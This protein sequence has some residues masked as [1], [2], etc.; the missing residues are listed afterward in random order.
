MSFYVLVK[1][2]LYIYYFLYLK[3]SDVPKDVPTDLIYI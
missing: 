3:F 1:I 2:K